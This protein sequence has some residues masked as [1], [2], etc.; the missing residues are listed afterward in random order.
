M[1]STISFL[2]SENFQALLDGLQSMGYRCVAPVPRDGAVVYDTV[3]RTDQ[4]PRGASVVQEPGSY[5]LH[6]GQHDRYFAWANGPQA[7]KPQLFKPRQQ[8]WSATRT[9]EGELEFSGTEARVE[10]VALIGVRACDLA[11]LYLQDKHF[12]QS[13]FVDVHYRAAREGLFVVAVQCTHPASTCFCAASGDGPR[14][15]YG[16]D[17]ALTEIDGGFVLEVLSTRGRSLADWLPLQPASKAQ[18]HAATEAVDHAEAQQTRRL[19]GRKLR[20]EL[21]GKLD[22]PRWSQVAE[23]CLSCG[24]CTAVCPTCFCHGEVDVAEL[25][26]GRSA[27]F[28]EWDSCF[29]GRHGY[30][31]GLNLRDQTR[32]RYRQ[33]LTHKFAGWHDQFGRSGCVGCGR[34][35]AWCPVGI[36]VTEE[37]DAICGGAVGE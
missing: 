36:D 4:L 28:R 7:L 5:R 29:A 9:V 34:C 24:N 12:L 3:T 30:I 27:H 20:D 33:W 15:D 25:D 19:P 8:L 23:R 21:Y 10:S 6:Q 35:I 26:G 13:T 31:H 16:Y 11:A 32:D 17:V 22:H 37:L 14:V 2:D 18:L 1:S